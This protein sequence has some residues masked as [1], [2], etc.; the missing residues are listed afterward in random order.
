MERRSLGRGLEALI[1]PGKAEKYEKTVYLKLDEIS[2]NPYQPRKEFDAQGLEELTQSIKAKG[3]IQP[4]IV[5]RKGETYELIAG[6]RRLRAA[7]LLNIK[8]I[9]A[10]IKDV[11]GA[12]SL[13]LSLIENIQRE[14]LN[15]IEQAHAFQYLV[16]KFQV[17]QEQI[18][19]V[20]GKSRAT[21]TNTL[22]LLKLPQEIQ[23]EIEQGK[24][25]FAHG[26]L[27]LELTDSNQQ[28]LLAHRIIANTLSVRDLENIVKR[29]QSRKL[30]PTTAKKHIDP[31]LM[32]IEEELQQLLGTRVKIHKARKRGCIRIEFYSQEDLDRILDILRK[33]S[34]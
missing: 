9:P 5:R 26:K 2:P 11:D 33:A 20:I 29:L 4:I 23:E 22:R 6:E 13:E 3:L 25:S 17:T 31:R 18:A 10:I 21:V 15:P 24:I 12:G 19:E 8:E 32:V 14:D 30:K 34:R 7:K 16:T 28:R 27:L 1:P